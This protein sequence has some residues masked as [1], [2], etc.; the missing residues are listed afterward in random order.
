MRDT[1]AVWRT[2][3]DAA[4]VGQRVWKNT[5]DLAWAAA[6]GE[7]NAYKALRKPIEIGAVTRH[8]A[9]AGGFSVTDPERVLTLFAAARS[10]GSAHRTRFEEAQQLAS[11]APV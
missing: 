9:P 4:L 7:K 8:P 11:T 10:L 2:L 5:G 3:A 1:D 6:V